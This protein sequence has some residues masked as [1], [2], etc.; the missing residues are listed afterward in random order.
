MKYA[1][2]FLDRHN[3]CIEIDIEIKGNYVVIHDD[4]Y[5]LRDL[6]ICGRLNEERVEKIINKFGVGKSDSGILFMFALKDS[7]NCVSNYCSGAY[8]L[9]QAILEIN[10]EVK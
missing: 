6:K 10:E 5:T 3:D 4:G 9:I 1:T 7:E 8:T 2:N